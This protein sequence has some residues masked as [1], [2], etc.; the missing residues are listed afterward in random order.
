MQ[1]LIVGDSFRKSR[2]ECVRIDT[3][4]LHQCMVHR[5]DEFVTYLYGDKARRIGRDWRV[6]Q[7]GSLLIQATNRIRFHDFETDTSGDAV[8][9]W[10]RA[11]QCSKAEALKA[12]AEWVGIAFDEFPMAQR[13]KPPKPS[14]E[15]RTVPPIPGREFDAWREGRNWLARSDSALEDLAAWR[16]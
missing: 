2:T 12:C 6:G 9:L 4:A 14:P 3:A 13:P 16:N 11:F 1:S 10:S 7:R 5:A 8:D 15:P